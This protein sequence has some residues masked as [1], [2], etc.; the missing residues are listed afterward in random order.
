MKMG[1]RES[2]Q[3]RVLGVLSGEQRKMSYVIVL[4]TV[5]V[6]FIQAFHST[7]WAE[8]LTCVLT[9]SWCMCNDHHT[10]NFAKNWINM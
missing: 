5:C 2:T 8:K 7:F 4:G 9:C 3:L 10:R 6:L 1:H